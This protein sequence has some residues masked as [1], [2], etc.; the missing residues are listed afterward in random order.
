MSA[1]VCGPASR[2]GVLLRWGMPEPIASQTCGGLLAQLASKTPA[3]GGGAAAGVT[4]AT[5]AALCGMVV[6]YSL[7]RKALAEHQGFLEQ[8][9]GRLE[10]ARAVFL[11]LAD[12]DAE[13]YGV[14]NALMRLPEDSPERAAGWAAAVDGALGPPRATLAGASD[15]LRLC[16]DLLGRVNP[17]LRSDLAVAAVLAEAAARSAAWNVSVNLPLLPDDRRGGVHAE[18]ERLVGD[19]RARAARVEDGCA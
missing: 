1:G 18:A 19:A 16:E 12:E 6:A 3:P 5:A 2:R 17:H 10:R 11:M 8:A 13:A 15:L 14:L 7:G 9:A 4:A